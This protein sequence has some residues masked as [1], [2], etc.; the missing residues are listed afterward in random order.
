MG[1]AAAL[2]LVLGQGQSHIRAD[3]IAFYDAQSHIKVDWTKAQIRAVLGSPDDIWDAKDSR[4]YVDRAH[5]IWCYGSNG[6]LTFPTLGYV[7]FMDGKVWRQSDSIPPQPLSVL[8][9]AELG[10]ALR[11]L[12]RPLSWEEPYDDP[13]RIVQETNILRP[14][15]A[16]KAIAVLMEEVR[17]R[18]NRGA[19]SWFPMIR[20]P[21]RSK[22]PAGFIRLPNIGG[23]IIQ[24]PKDMTK[25][26]DFPAL[27]TDGVPMS[28]PLQFNVGGLPERLEWYLQA[29]G[30]KWKVRDQPIRPPD[31]PFLAY[32]KA[33]A[34]DRLSLIFGPGLSD[35]V[36]HEQSLDGMYDQV[37]Q[38]VRTAWR[39]ANYLGRDHSRDHEAFLAAH[40]HWDAARM[41]YVRSDGS[42]T[43]D[44]PAPSNFLY[45][46]SGV[47]RLDLKVSISRTQDW[48]LE[49]LATCKESPGDPLADALMVVQDETT[50][51]SHYFIVNQD[52][53]VDSA[54]LPK[55]RP[56]HAP[57]ESVTTDSTFKSDLGH[58]LKLVLEFGGKTYSSL[59]FAP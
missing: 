58:K 39:P 5:E 11:S 42:F 37:R 20:F 41:M 55:P 46:F 28:I 23:P 52:M 18:P 9:D 6:H 29:E 17:L 36:R 34:S 57:K 33:L 31:D 47:P 8:S 4:L 35:E 53:V 45:S 13:L 22:D 44:S 54:V 59:E 21:F 27:E 3:R 40:C 50:G 14:L 16:K 19:H 43:P 32:K 15:G 10:K 26:P 7:E 25:W 24:P 56:P 48:G 2:A 12:D 51:K 38:L 30:S 49:F 1:I